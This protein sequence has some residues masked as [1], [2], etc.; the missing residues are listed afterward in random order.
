MN[1]CGEVFTNDCKS[2]VVR[3]MLKNTTSNKILSTKCKASSQT[4]DIFL[5]HRDTTKI[6]I[7]STVLLEGKKGA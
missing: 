6:K 3:S 1:L 2:S 5:L 7:I 4:I